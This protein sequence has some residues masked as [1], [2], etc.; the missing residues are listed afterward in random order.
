MSDGRWFGEE[1]PTSLSPYGQRVHVPLEADS[2]SE[3][4]EAGA[5][6]LLAFMATSEMHEHEA[7][8]LNITD[9]DLA[10]QLPPEHS[11]VSADGRMDV[12][13]KPIVSINGKDVDEH[14]E[15][16]RDAA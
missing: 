7:A 11:N 8:D 13:R 6:N 15:H 12:H 2:Y 16:L 14:E 5:G 1:F 3:R 10:N 9:R 4:N